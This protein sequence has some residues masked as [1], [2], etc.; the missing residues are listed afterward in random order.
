MRPA[1]RIVSRTCLRKAAC[2]RPA[3]A[4]LSANVIASVSGY[5]TL[6][7][8]ERY[9]RAAD[10]KRMAGEG[11]KAISGREEKWQPG[12][13]K[14]AIMENNMTKQALRPDLPF[15]GRIE[16]GGVILKWQA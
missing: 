1:C 12:F 4:G 6:Q 15:V 13:Q 10:R 9:T 5:S 11:M 2:R 8:V 16:G 7:E 14:V 3:E